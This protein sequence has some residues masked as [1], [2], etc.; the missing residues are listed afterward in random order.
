MCGRYVSPDEAAMERSW[1][2]SRRN[3]ADWFA[4]RF[5]VAPSTRVPIIRQATGGGLELDAARWG[6]IPGWW[7]NDALPNLT[8]N[9][10]SEEAADKPTWRQGLR[11]M[12]CLMPA[13]G[14]YEWNEQEPA[15]SESGRKG[16]QPYFISCPSSE[17]IAFAGLWSLWRGPTP[18]AAPVLSCALLS[19]AAAP[20]IAAIHHRMP[21][22]LAP[23]QQAA[24]LDPA[25]SPQTVAQLIASARVDFEGY[26]VSTRV[27]NTRNDG[28]ELLERI[29]R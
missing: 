15:V 24:W 14:W 25:S 20:S 26:P 16:K 10:R 9:A 27:G 7:K 2:I 1:R 28:P 8:F 29:T 4:P 17:V 6:L 21:V 5:N 18:D 12:R 11:S 22:V 19:R 3:G 13:H 23:E